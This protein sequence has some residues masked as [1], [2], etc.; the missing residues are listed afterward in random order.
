MGKTIR[1]SLLLLLLTCPAR[2]GWIQNGSPDP[3][4]PPSS[5]AQEPSADGNIPN[6]TPNSITGIALDLLAVLPSLF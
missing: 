5:V 1:A 4:P 3:A 6:H 2:A